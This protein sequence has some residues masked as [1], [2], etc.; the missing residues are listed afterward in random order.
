MVYS[1][2]TVDEASK[3]VCPMGINKSWKNLNALGP[4]AWHGGG[5]KTQ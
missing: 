5:Q 4:N 2:V 1:K 3:K